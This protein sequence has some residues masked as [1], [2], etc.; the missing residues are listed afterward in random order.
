MNRHK[1]L[2]HHHWISLLNI[3]LKLGTFWVQGQHLDAEM[4][5]FNLDAK[6]HSIRLAQSCE[7]SWSDF[8]HHDGITMHQVTHSCMNE[9]RNYMRKSETMLIS[10][11][12]SKVFFI[13]SHDA[14]MS[15][16]FFLQI[17]LSQNIILPSNCCAQI[18]PISL[19]FYIIPWQ[20]SNENDLAL[21]QVIAWCWT[22]ASV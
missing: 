11:N 7:H 8:C 21:H 5:F 9:N 13:D 15:L 2:F 17:T 12:N 16:L 1:L 6:I 19:A 3:P 22:G 10:R 20:L 4:F 18:K 14:H